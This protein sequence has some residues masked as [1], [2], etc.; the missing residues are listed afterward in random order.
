MQTFFIAW[1]ALCCGFFV[2]YVICGIFKR[3]EEL[4]PALEPVSV[5]LQ[6]TTPQ[7]MEEMGEALIQAG[8]LLKSGHFSYLSGGIVVGELGNGIINIK[9]DVSLRAV[10]K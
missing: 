9:G 10:E 5:P 7:A 6:H 4:N 2:G 1:F 8:E 3:V